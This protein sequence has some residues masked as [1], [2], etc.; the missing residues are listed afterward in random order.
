MQRRTFIKTIPALGL[1]PGG[2]SH[3]L[4]TGSSI[5]SEQPVE[6]NWVKTFC[7]ECTGWCPL[8]VRVSNGR[9][10][11]IR[12]NRASTNK[13]IICSKAVTALQQLYSQD[14]LQKPLI[15]TSPRGTG[16]HPGW[17]TITWDQALER[18]A[19]EL[20]KLDRE[21]NQQALTLCCSLSAPHSSQLVYRAFASGFG[22]SK[23]MR[24]HDSGTTNWLLGQWLADGA[25][26]RELDLSSSKLLLFFGASINDGS[27]TSVRLQQAWHQLRS[28]DHPCR[29][30]VVDPHYSVL[31]SRAEQWLP[32][33]AATEASLALGMAHIILT[34]GLWDREFVGDFVSQQDFVTGRQVANCDFNSRQTTGLISWWNKVLKDYSPAL[35]ALETGIAEEKIY[36][37]ARDFAHQQPAV[38]IAGR[39]TGS[40][41]N[42]IITS[43]TIHA[44]NGLVGSIDSDSI[45]IYPSQAAR[46]KEV[47]LTELMTK[48][49]SKTEVLL[50]CE[51]RSAPSLSEEEGD[52]LEAMSKVPFV[53]QLTN[54]FNCRTEYADLV[55][56][57]PH[58]LE[59]L[60]YTYQE[61]P[62]CELRYGQPV[63]KRSLNSRQAPEIL[64]ELAERLE[65]KTE[66]VV[67]HRQE[68]LPQKLTPE[69]K[70]QGIYAFDSHHKNVVA[71]GFGT[72]S[73]KF[74]FSSS[75]LHKLIP[76]LRTKDCCPEYLPLAWG[77]KS[78]DQYLFTLTSPL[79][80]VAAS[81]KG[82][83]LTVEINPQSAERLGLTAGSIAK[84]SSDRS[85]IEVKV[86]LSRAI[87]PQIIALEARDRL[88]GRKI[89][90]ELLFALNRLV[91]IKKV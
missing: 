82:D 39:H 31:A 59:S 2:F 50:D 23:R 65:E 19:V 53:A 86:R 74:E 85:E 48:D 40:L 47:A 77:E 21:N 63:V 44:L 55:L 17:K 76:Q 30:V 15:R 14:S 60:I 9:A 89:T 71:D 41:S 68:L 8:E 88:E 73:G 10:V 11:G 81:R 52:Y 22:T 75:N 28:E 26:D 36:Q 46:N 35:A 61:G 4:K 5:K 38:A 67:M 45:F 27:W 91:T 33:A 66:R 34:E 84:I 1:I 56:P 29:L 3:F 87:N 13:G 32:I 25:L 7:I 51:E 69:R 72:P 83:P 54:N 6:E 70:K 58:F 79:S 20:E 43:F 78:N 16:E 62:L 24:Y 42:G 12:G 57:T 80:S 37:L 18:L 64:M 49:L 90:K